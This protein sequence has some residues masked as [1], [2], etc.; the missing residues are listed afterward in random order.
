MPILLRTLVWAACLPLLWPPGV[1]PHHGP[2]DLVDWLVSGEHPAPGEPH[3]P[4]CPE[5]GGA[6]QARLAEPAA[7]LTLDLPAAGERVTVVRPAGFNPA[8][9]PEPPP[10]SSP[11][12]YLTHCSLVI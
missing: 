8:A 9:R 12:L 7:G 6:D 3:E 10:H 1:C 11:P 2:A 4:C 5:C